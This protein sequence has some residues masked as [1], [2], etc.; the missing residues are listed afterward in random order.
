MNFLI[1]LHGF[2]LM[3]WCRKWNWMACAIQENFLI[4][5]HGFSLILSIASAMVLQMELDGMRY[6]RAMN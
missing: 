4:A 5:L 1:A 2:S 6:S 3:L